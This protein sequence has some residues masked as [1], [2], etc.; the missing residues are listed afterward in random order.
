M[1]IPQ[2]IF[3][4]L[5]TARLDG[6]QLAA[7][8]PEVTDDLARELT[9]WGPA[10]D[11]LL[12]DSPAAVSINFHPLQNEQFCLSRTTRTGAEYSG[13]AGGCIQ[14]LMF[15]L[16]L[17]DVAR[18][19]NHPFAILRAMA[20]AGRLQVAQPASSRLRSVPLVG[21]RLPGPLAL[22]TVD[23]PLDAAVFSDLV[24]TLSRGDC[25]VVVSSLSVENVL[26][27][28]FNRLPED[29]RLEISFSTGLRF[30]PRRA[31]RLLAAPKDVAE[32]RQLARQP[33]VK[34]VS[35][36]ALPAI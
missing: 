21:R 28:L 19:N 10:H 31:F 33:G 12:S 7:W 35:L 25:A 2:A 17:A 5:R 9:S 16:S 20:A 13:R 24:Q 29:R 23:E 3:T 8:S 22:Q 4:S 6:Y 26:I 32:Q 30:S 1:R 15:V 27:S 18:F 14:T 11:S 34:I 36:D